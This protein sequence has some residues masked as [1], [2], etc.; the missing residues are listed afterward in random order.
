MGGRRCGET[1]RAQSRAR[2]VSVAPDGH[3]V[4]CGPACRRGCVRGGSS[5]RALKASTGR[6]ASE[7]WSGLGRHSRR[8]GKHER[9]LGGRR[10][11]RGG[12]GHGRHCRH[13]CRCQGSRGRAA[14]CGGGGRGRRSGDRFALVQGRRGQWRWRRAC[15]RRRIRSRMRCG[16]RTLVSLGWRWQAAGGRIDGRRRRC[17][18]RGPVLA[19]RPA[20]LPVGGHADAARRRCGARLDQGCGR[21][22]R[23]SLLGR[24]GVALAARAPPPPLPARGGR[25]RRRLREHCSGDAGARPSCCWRPCQGRRWRL[26][27]AL[28]AYPCRRGRRPLG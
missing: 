4:V 6:Y 11:R 12:P 15:C 14:G 10:R 13:V 17:G 3:V 23:R 2:S 8:A 9:G 16:R 20:S 27:C 7:A 22:S 21:V 19:S 5:G 1:I 25:R 18:R 24:Q 28:T 26:C